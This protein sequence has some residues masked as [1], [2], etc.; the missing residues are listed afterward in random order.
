MINGVKR[1]YLDKEKLEDKKI[2][3]AIMSSFV[4]L[5]IQYFFYISFDLIG[6]DNVSS[7]LLISKVSVGLIFMYT[8]PVVFKRTKIKLLVVY[9]F[10]IFIVVVNFI[11]FPENKL[12]LKELIIPFFFMCLP[13]FI[14]SMAIVDWSILK[15]IMKKASL[16]VFIFGT[17]LGILIFSGRA[18]A[19]TY[20]MSL[21]YYMLLPTIMY[22]DELL[23][24][25]SLKAFFIS[26]VSLLVILALGSR[27]AVLCILVFVA[28]K[29]IRFDLKMNYFR[30]IY[31]VFSLGTIII[32]YMN[33][34]RIFAFL[35]RTLLGYGI[36][37]RS[38]NLFL[39][40]EVSLSGRDRLFEN[41][42]QE[43]FNNPFLGIGIGGDRRILG[44]GYVHNIFLEIA[45]NFGI[46]FGAVLIM[47]LILLII[48]CL[49]I[50]DNGKYS[51]FTIWISIGFAH[52]MV[53]SSYLTD[54]KFW[55]MLG[56][57]ISTF[58]NKKVKGKSFRQEL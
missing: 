44:G 7:I 50:K 23:D 43:V 35:Y 47:F 42:Y 28:L 19:G 16:I 11:L 31:Y 12:Y 54:I 32:I 58:F 30:A 2:S 46:I 4:I 36:N 9:F 24:K 21:S 5:T 3:I 29:H 40:E 26:A 41:V 8:L 33:L 17:F 13:A 22:L 1:N 51:V 39:R 55:I 38:L 45:A 10:S 27:G 49:L 34:D 6:T 25:L 56:L 14:Y 52:L 20:S 53:S 15:Q 37:S 48:K 18:S 57:I